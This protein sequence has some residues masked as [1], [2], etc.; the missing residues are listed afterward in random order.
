MNLETPVKASAR[1]G[2]GRAPKPLP[3]PNSDFYELYGTLKPEELATVKRVREFLE[4]KVAPII[5]K[6]WTEDSF[7]FELLPAV[8]GLGIGGVGLKGYGCAGGRLA[9]LGFCPDGARTGRSVVRDV[10]R[11]ACRSGNGFD[12]H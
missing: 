6:Y 11:R 4:N 3:A 7:P 8:K 2:K 1:D 12:L 10:L 5:T 9:L